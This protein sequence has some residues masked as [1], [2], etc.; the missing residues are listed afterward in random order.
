LPL[1]RK[2]ITARSLVC[3]DLALDLMVLPVSYVYLNI[4]AVLIVAVFAASRVPGLQVWTWLGS[5]CAAAAVLY[6]LRGWQ[7]SGAGARG[8][9]DLARAPFF[10]GWKLL[11]LFSRGHS[12]EWVRTKR[13]NS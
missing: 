12:K 2:A 8:L 3:L 13:E 1:L 11:V 5:G 6:I 4:A 10:L 7:L 9:L